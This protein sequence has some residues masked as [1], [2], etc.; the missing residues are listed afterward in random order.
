MDKHFNCHATSICESINIGKGTNIWAFCNILKE[1]VIGDDCNICDNVFIENKVVIGDRVTIKCGVQVW[2]GI[3]LGDDVFI[4][5]NAT[6]C[7]DNYPRSKQH[8]DVFPQT[9]VEIGASIGANATILPGIT[10][11]QNAMIGAGSVVTQNVPANAVVVGNP[12]RIINYSSN[13]TGSKQTN[14]ELNSQ[15]G[16]LGIGDCELVKLPRFSDM[17]GDL[18]VTEFEKHLPFIPKRSFFV[19]GVP[20][21]KVRGEHAHYRCKQFL[22]ALSGTV[23]VV[24]DDG[25]SRK[26]VILNSP[27]FGVYLSPKVWGI[28]YKFSSSAVLCV[29]ASHEYQEEDYIRD[30]QEFLSIRS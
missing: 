26:E 22:I 15:F 6:F 10:I 8:L 1:A 24:L 18:M 27:D 14:I 20:S 28:Q 21:N 7:N 5:P 12:A 30:Y 29:F 25:V 2:D 11:G 3:T 13:N 17:R 9:V 4:G 16:K 23:N 19:F